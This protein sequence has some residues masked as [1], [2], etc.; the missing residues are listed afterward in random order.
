MPKDLSSDLLIALE[1]PADAAE[2]LALVDRVFGPGRYAKAAERLREGNSF[3]P[4]LSFV[5]RENGRLVGS[6]RLWPVRICA[7][8]ALLLG[9]I[10]VDPAAQRRGLGHALSAHAC[11]AAASAGHA[12]VVLVGD[13]AFFERVGFEALEPGRIRL[14]GPADPRRVLVKALRPG[15]WDGVEGE[16]A[17]P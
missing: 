4:E 17:L 7:A 16:V 13:M 9:P 14:P 5:A 3:L 11:D 8:E 2:A 12:R 10:A 6:V 15:A 1:A